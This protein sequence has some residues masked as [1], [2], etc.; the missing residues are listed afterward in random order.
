M[1]PK[2][3]TR[4][5]MGC[6][7]PLAIAI[8]CVFSSMVLAT[9]PSLSGPSQAVA[10]DIVQLKGH[11]L[12]LNSSL[13]IEVH[14]DDSSHSELIEVG[15]DGS[16]NFQLYT[17]VEGTYRVLMFDEQHQLITSTLVLVRPAGD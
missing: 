9:T 4:I 17:S 13:R 3:N 14:S 2:H 15:A 12:P 8:S 7:K 10:G 5:S 11:H 16:T 1:K 6:I